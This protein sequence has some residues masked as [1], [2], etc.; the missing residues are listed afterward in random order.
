M[1]HC[2]WQLVWGIYADMLFPPN[3]AQY[4]QSFPLFFQMQLYKTKLKREETFLLA[5]QI[6]S[7]RTY[8]VFLE[9]CSR[10]L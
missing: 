7:S 1:T 4:D 8:S 10:K 6:Q 2:A 5:N 3:V 9:L